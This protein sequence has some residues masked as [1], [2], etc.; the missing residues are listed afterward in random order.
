ML[1]T[2]MVVGGV[3]ATF[4]SFVSLG[5]I[6]VMTLLSREIGPSHDSPNCVGDI[7]RS[8]P[9]VGNRQRHE[10]WRIWLGTAS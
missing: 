7:Q 4:R 6:G 5:L 9:V 2:P 3:K 10:G 1:A 8:G